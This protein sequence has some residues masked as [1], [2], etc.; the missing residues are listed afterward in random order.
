M[1]MQSLAERLLIGLIFLIAAL[2]VVLAWLTSSSNNSCDELGD[3]AA[4]VCQN[5]EPPNEL[6]FSS[7]RS[8]QW[9]EAAFDGND[10]AHRVKM[11]FRNLRTRQKLPLAALWLVSADARQ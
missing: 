2:A 8:P 11:T 9:P 5:I 10:P 4:S 6:K 1:A 3:W 7:A